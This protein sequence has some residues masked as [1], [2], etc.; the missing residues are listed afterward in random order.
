L[1]NHLT[2]LKIQWP[3]ENPSVM[4]VVEQVMGYLN[5]YGLKYGSLSSYQSTWF[6][7]REGDRLFVSKVLAFD[8]LN[9]RLHRCI[10]YLVSLARLSPTELKV[11]P[12][13]R[14]SSRIANRDP[15][16]ESPPVSG[17]HPGRLA[18]SRNSLGIPTALSRNSGSTCDLDLLITFQLRTDRIHRFWILWQG[19]RVE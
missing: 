2:D 13:L 19:V 3:Q 5:F 4:N 11:E 12:V 16:D 15:M 17:E 6:L 7:Q 8:N 10:G 9:L 1:D 18:L 14:R